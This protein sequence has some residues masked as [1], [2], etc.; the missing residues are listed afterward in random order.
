MA[1]ATRRL[2]DL[3][4][5]AGPNDTLL[6][7]TLDLGRAVS[8]LGHGVAGIALALHRAAELDRTLDTPGLREA[9]RAAHAFEHG[10]YSEKLGTWLDY[11]SSAMPDTAMHGICSGAPGIG[12]ALLNMGGKGE[13]TREDL[14]RAIQTCL[15][16]PRLYRDHL[17]CGNAATVDFLLEVARASAD[18]AEARA[19]RERAAELLGASHAAGWRLLPPMYRDTPDTSLFYGLA[20]VGYELLRL[21]DPELGAVIS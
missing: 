8:G 13:H 7:D 3:R 15:T 19:C 18:P 11:R 10:A 16:R 2:I 5:L 14:Q 21:I 6:W 17:C 9:V 1:R 4:T 12:L 20:G